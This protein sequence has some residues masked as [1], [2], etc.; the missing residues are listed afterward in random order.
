M[1]KQINSVGIWSV[2]SG[3]KV[4]VLCAILGATEVNAS[5]YSSAAL[6]SDSKEVKAE[7]K[8]ENVMGR[9]SIP[10]VSVNDNRNSKEPITSI[11]SNWMSNSSYWSPDDSL[12]NSRK[13]SDKKEKTVKSDQAQ[14]NHSAENKPFL[15]NAE[16]YIHNSEF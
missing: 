13:I 7:L 10:F 5:N 2:K 1:K 12:L 8:Y 11:I 9:N 15:F 6:N 14:D 16:N 3:L 4:T